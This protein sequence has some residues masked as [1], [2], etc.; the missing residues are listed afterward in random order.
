MLSYYKGIASH[1][2]NFIVKGGE[3]S[4]R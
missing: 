2:T 1:A 4:E 3:K